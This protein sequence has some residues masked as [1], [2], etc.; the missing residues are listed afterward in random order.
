MHSREPTR[1][2]AARALAMPCAAC[3]DALYARPTTRRS[4]ERP[5]LARPIRNGSL[6]AATQRDWCRGKHV[7]APTG[8][9]SLA[10]RMLGEM[11]EVEERISLKWDL[12]KG[13]DGTVAS[14]T[15][16]SFV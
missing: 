8:A 16:R 10:Y 5:A 4:A 12:L 11:Q 3:C 14:R 13:L 9:E 6:G 15:Q 2:A 7:W 1:R